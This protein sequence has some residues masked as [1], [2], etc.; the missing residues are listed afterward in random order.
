MKIAACSKCGYEA[1]E[2]MFQGG[3]CEGCRLMSQ[4]KKESV[5]AKVLQELCQCGCGLRVKNSKNRFASP[6]CYRRSKPMPICGCGCGYEVLRRDR[7]YASLKCQFRDRVAMAQRRASMRAAALLRYAKQR[8]ED[9]NLP[10]P[11]RSA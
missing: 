7:K 4:V 11:R 8:G 5:P 6:E 2:S 10:S 1:S 3:L 9:V